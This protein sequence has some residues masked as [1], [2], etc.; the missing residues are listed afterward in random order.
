MTWNAGKIPTVGIIGTINY[1]R[2]V[3]DGFT[4][5][6]LGGIMY[7]ILG[8]HY[9]SGGSIRIR[10]VANYGYDIDDKIERYLKDKEN[11]DTGG[12][13]KQKGR[14][15][16]VVLKD[17]GLQGKREILKYRVRELSFR[18]V[19]S[20]VDCDLIL[21]NFISGRDVKLDT[22]R[23]LRVCY[24]SI[25]YI[26]V[27]SFT[28]GIKRNGQR[29]YRRPDKWEDV[30]STADIVQMNLIEMLTVLGE[31]KITLS[32]PVHYRIDDMAEKIL[33]IG[34][35][36]FI[37][38][39]GSIGAKLFYRSDNGI[40]VHFSK[41]QLNSVTGGEATGCGDLLSAAFIVSMMG[42]TKLNDTL[43]YA[44]AVAVEKFKRPGL[45]SV[46]ELIRYRKVIKG[47]GFSIDR[48]I[49]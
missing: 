30:V 44:V 6:D 26:D 31:K 28:L 24:N 27:H 37:L 39:L 5:E 45:S 13:Y 18:K 43:D 41:A 7:N 14:N 46:S 40:K 32:E 38:T 29:Y 12:L 2:V 4:C 34:P 47:E 25:I 36:V 35:R 42:G 49:F 16:S 21:V 8:L 11:I 17:T 33:N 20:L 48:F 22:L 3:G 1:D 10:P 19:K 15:P 9:L 23:K